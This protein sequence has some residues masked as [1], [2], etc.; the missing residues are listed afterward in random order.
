MWHGI[1]REREMPD[2]GRMLRY[3]FL[4]PEGDG[5]RSFIPRP[6]SDFEF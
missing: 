3:P 6:R 5:L 2:M 4:P 1:G